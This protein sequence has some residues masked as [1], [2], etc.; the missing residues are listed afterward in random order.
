MAGLTGKV[1]KSRASRQ[2]AAGAWR[3]SIPGRAKCSQVPFAE[4]VLVVLCCSFLQGCLVSRQQGKGRSGRGS[5]EGPRGVWDRSLL[6]PSFL[7]SLRGASGGAATTVL[8]PAAVFFFT[9]LFDRLSHCSPDSSRT[10]CSLCWPQT[11]HTSAPSLLS[12][13]FTSHHS[14]CGV[15]F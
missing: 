8:L 10:R 9:F 5:G 1:V 6:S 14:Q 2:L 7:N 11:L 4:Y 12:D 13:G 15:G 3:W